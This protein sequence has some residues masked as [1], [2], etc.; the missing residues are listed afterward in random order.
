MTEKPER[1]LGGNVKIV[2]KRLADG[3][4]KEYRYDRAPRRRKLRKQFGA[5]QQLADL[6]AR[7]PEFLKLSKRWQV[8]KHHY[9]RLLENELDWMTVDD[10]ND[11]EARADF[12]ELRDR[13]VSHPDKADK[14]ID[15]L[16]GMLGWAYERNRLAYNHALGIPHLAPSGK[17]RS[18]I[19]W[20]E[21]HE[22]IVYATF[23]RPL[24]EAFRFALFSA[25]RQADMC[26]LRWENY[27]DG[28]ITYRQSKTGTTVR[29]PVFALPPFQE[30]VDGLSRSSEF[31][32]TTGTGHPMDVAHLGK[33]FREAY[34]KSELKPFGLRWHDIRGTAATRLTEAGCT[35]AEVAAITG[36]SIG[37]GTKLGDYVARSRALAVHAYEKWSQAMEQ[38]PQIVTLETRRGN[39][40][41]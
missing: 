12:Y 21:D 33:T 25:A 1:P 31:M 4:V 34:A 20:T 15:T 32:L 11:R 35:D 14:L 17:R 19:I 13:Y 28:W 24:V 39:R 30:L 23:P 38:R 2:R 27:R 9:L 36:H 29:L 7:S 26:R 40:T 5:I 18:D 22:A 16:K 10:L 8:A 37:P 41:K 3:T 6:Y